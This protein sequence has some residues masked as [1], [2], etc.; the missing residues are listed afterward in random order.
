MIDILAEAGAS[1]FHN[2]VIREFTKR[3]IKSTNRA[4]PV[5]IA[6]PVNT[7]LYTSKVVRYSRIS[8]QSPKIRTLTDTMP[9]AVYTIV[10]GEKGKIFSS[11][12]NKIPTAVK[13]YVAFP[14]DKKKL[15]KADADFVLCFVCFGEE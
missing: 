13:L 15:Y 7:L 5:F 6:A 14:Q 11:S 2:Q 12:N 8:R 1:T 10:E 9:M 4:G 3:K